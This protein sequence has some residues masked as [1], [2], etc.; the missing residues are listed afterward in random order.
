MR[1]M[2]PADYPTLGDI[3]TE[4]FWNDEVFTWVFPHRAH[5][6]EDFKNTWM[7]MFRFHLH[8]PGWHCF[9]SET[10]EVDPIWSGQSDLTGFAMWERQGHSIAAKSWQQDNFS[11][12]TSVFSIKSLGVDKVDDSLAEVPS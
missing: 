2:L 4:A 1:R 3:A 6:P 10:E 7:D 5:F 9:V 8:K 12:S 11:N